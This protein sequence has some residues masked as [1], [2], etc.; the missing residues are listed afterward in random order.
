MQ[1]FVRENS[2]LPQFE[3]GKERLERISGDRQERFRRCCFDEDVALRSFWN[4]G[5]TS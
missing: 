4:C 3:S 5:R 1:D 2:Y